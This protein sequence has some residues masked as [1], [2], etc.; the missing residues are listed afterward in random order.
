LHD[1]ARGGAGVFVASALVVSPYRTAPAANEP[2]SA[3]A[4]DAYVIAGGLVVLAS[5]RV[6]IAGTT[7]GLEPAL[8]VLVVAALGAWSARRAPARIRAW[9]SAR[10]LH[11]AFRMTAP[12]R[13]CVRAGSASASVRADDTVRGT[14]AAT[15]GL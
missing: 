8:A 2:A 11:R 6:A 10:R 4:R 15:A 13:S 1:R 9:Q 12:P 5:V 7:F 14:P 3:P